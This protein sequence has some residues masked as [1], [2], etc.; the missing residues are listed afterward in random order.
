LNKN[1]IY[2]DARYIAYDPVIHKSSTFQVANEV[3]LKVQK[4][5]TAVC[6][7]TLYCDV[8]ELEAICQDV[9]DEQMVKTN[10]I[11]GRRRRYIP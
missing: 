5:M 8:T 6:G 11:L 1:C 2:R 7:D 3:K 4:K 9:L 10:D